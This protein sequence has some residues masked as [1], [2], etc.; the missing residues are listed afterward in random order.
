MDRDPQHSRDRH[1]QYRYNN[2]DEHG[3]L[4]PTI[5]GLQTGPP[6]RSTAWPRSSTSSCRSAKRR[7]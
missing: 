2:V 4:F 6:C 3:L 1:Y 5:L 7:F